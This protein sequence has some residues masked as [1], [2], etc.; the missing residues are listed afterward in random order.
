MEARRTRLR[1][2]ASIY[3]EK[4]G[5][6]FRGNYFPVKKISTRADDLRVSTANCNE[7]SFR[8]GL[9]DGASLATARGTDSDASDT[10]LTAN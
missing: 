8:K 9:I 10:D 5:A 3:S 1:K 6:K 4:R 7:R 2:Q